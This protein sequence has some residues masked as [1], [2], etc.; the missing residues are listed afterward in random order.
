MLTDAPPAEPQAQLPASTGEAQTP[1]AEANP[2]PVTTVTAEVYTGPSTYINTRDQLELDVIRIQQD[3]VDTEIVVTG[4]TSAGEEPAQIVYEAAHVPQALQVLCSPEGEGVELGVVAQRPENVVSGVIPRVV[5]GEEEGEVVVAVQADEVPQVASVVVTQTE[6]HP[7]VAIAVGN[8]RREGERKR[9][10]ITLPV[11]TL[12]P[13]IL[14]FVVIFLK[15]GNLFLGALGKFCVKIVLSL[16][17]L[18]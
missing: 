16:L 15:T 17:G 12:V 4:A 2:G 10:T 5:S 13:A 6:A 8:H 14:V 11:C 3:S 9:R 18:Y 1:T 7:A